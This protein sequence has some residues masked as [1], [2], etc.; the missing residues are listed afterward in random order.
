MKYSRIELAFCLLLSTA[1]LSAVEWGFEPALAA[2]GLTWA[3]AGDCALER[4]YPRG[5]CSGG[6][7]CFATVTAVCG[8]NK[9]RLEMISGINGKEAAKYMASQFT[10]VRMLYGGRAEYPGMVTTRTEVPTELTARYAEKGPLGKGALY[11]P[12]SEGMAYGSGSPDLVK[13]AAALSYRYCAKAKTL[14][15]VEIFAPAGTADAALDAML[16]NLGC[17]VK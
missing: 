17:A 9:V 1:V 12:A 2:F 11:M 3:G 14:G 4:N 16:E 15:Q 5:S 13:Y 10:R 8:G 7:K 6:R